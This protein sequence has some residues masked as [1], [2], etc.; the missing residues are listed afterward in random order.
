MSKDYKA[1][2][3]KF[4]AKN[5]FKGKGPLCVALVVTEHARK[6]SLPLNSSNLVTE[7]GGQVLGLGK[8]AVQAIL[9]RHDIE[10]L[11]AAEG[12]RT[13]RGSLSNMQKYVAFLNGLHRKG[14][15]DLDAIEN[16]WIESVRAFFA[17][18]PFTIRLD[19][20]RGLRHIVRDILEQATARQK[21]APG[22]HYAGAVL[23]HLVGAKLDC[24]LGIGKFE[25]NS[26]STADAPS[27]RAGD[28]FVGDVA[29][30]VTTA[31]G[32]AVID[33]CRDNLNDG[34]KPVLVTTQRGVTIA[35]GLA[36]NKDLADRIDVFEIEQFVAL[37]LYELGKFAADG[38]RVAVSDLVSRYNDIVG[39]IETD[40][41]LKI[42]FRK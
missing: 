21:S 1:E 31:P 36:E 3:K 5:R 26:F 33:R 19:Y 6:M 12:G 30:H 11:L 29:I 41:S 22:L 8:G 13:S 4:T 2:L 35:E 20:S 38:R 34:Y 28:F 9:R 18:K 32:E 24:A 17:G 42:D 7:G 25:H 23:Q 14:M 27:K 40:P 16:F 15:A 39:E 37:N 10:R